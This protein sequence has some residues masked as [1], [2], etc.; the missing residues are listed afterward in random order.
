MQPLKNKKIIF[1]HSCQTIVSVLIFQQ[2]CDILL[3]FV[4]KGLNMKKFMNLL[5]TAAL[6]L[7]CGCSVVKCGT[8]KPAAPAVKKVRFGLYVDTGA[9]GN[10]VF[11]LASLVAHSPQAEL[12]L[13]MV[14]DIRKGKLNDIDVLIM[15]GGGSRKQCAAIGKEHWEKIH[16]FIRNGGGYVGTCAGMFNVLDH[17][18]GLLP[19]SRHIGAGGSTAYVTVDITPEGAKILGLESAGPRVVRYSGGPTAYK[20]KNSKCEGKGIS[21]ATFKTSVSRS[22]SAHGKKFIG[23]DALL[24]GTLGKGKIAAVSFHPEY[25]ESTHDIM[26]GCF[27][28]ASGVKLTPEFPRK[29]YRPVRAGIL[30]IGLNGKEPLE[31]MLKLE[32]EADID[33]DYVMGAEL[34]QGIL[35]HL[36]YLIIPGSKKEIIKKYLSSKRLEKFMN[37]GGVIIATGDVAG[38]VPDHKNFIKLP[39]DSDVRKYILK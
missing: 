22:T 31:M 26:L 5:F 30:S 36:D 29:N 23:T 2:G 6:I 16:S 38:I 25:W 28:A 3:H 12:E 37:G 20:V 19:F 8:D 35:N 27:Y 11:H 34:N 18:L 24:Y 4:Q 10:G 21:L 13:L 33:L 32:R 14:D 39:A 9:S 17:L 15:P 1:L 7:I